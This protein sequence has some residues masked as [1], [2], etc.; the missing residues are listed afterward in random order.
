MSQR[1]SPT[2]AVRVGW[3]LAHGTWFAAY[4][5]TVS[6]GT[7]QYFC[8]SWDRPKYDAG[9]FSTLPGFASGKAP[10]V[11]WL[12]ILGL[13]GTVGLL[14]LTATAARS[15]WVASTWNGA[16]WIFGAAVVV[17]LVLIQTDDGAFCTGGSLLVAAF[18]LLVL[19]AAGV[20]PL[21]LLRSDTTKAASIHPLSAGQR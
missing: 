6:A 11:E 14:A 13:V 4:L 21:R 20:P 10:Y 18:G 5:V 8:S 16:I 12:L 2:T 9:P 1:T 15:M 17:I 7:E 19:V 3:P